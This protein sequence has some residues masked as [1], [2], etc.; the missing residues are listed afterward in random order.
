MWEGDLVCVC[1]G[2]YSYLDGLV[3]DCSTSSA[4]AWRYCSL[5][6]SHWILTESGHLYAAKPIQ[7]QGWKNK[8]KGQWL[9]D[10]LKILTRCGWLQNC[11]DIHKFYEDMWSRW[12]VWPVDCQWYSSRVDSRFALSQWETSFQSYSDLI[13]WAQTSNQPWAHLGSH[14]VWGAILTSCASDLKFWC[15]F[16]RSIIRKLKWNL[17]KFLLTNCGLVMPFDTIELAQRWLR[18]FHRK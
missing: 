4:L 13:G 8:T 16:I 17:S 1:E 9:W 14:G 2:I 6:L 7:F 11:C 15:Q 12:D 18:Q 3:Q 5:T 10:I